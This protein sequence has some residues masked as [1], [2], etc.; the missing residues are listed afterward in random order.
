VPLRG[1]VLLAG[2]AARAAHEK[3]AR[4]AASGHESLLFVAVREGHSAR[5]ECRAMLAL[6]RVGLLIALGMIGVAVATVVLVEPRLP[7]F[8]VPSQGGD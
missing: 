2:R 8:N 5:N 4:V 7:K 1:S 6:R 3:L